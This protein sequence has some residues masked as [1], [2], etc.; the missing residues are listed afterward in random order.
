VLTRLCTKGLQDAASVLCNRLSRL[1]TAA[2]SRVGAALPV[3]RV[4]IG[5]PPREHVRVHWG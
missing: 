4:C 1:E 3:V 5:T 2:D